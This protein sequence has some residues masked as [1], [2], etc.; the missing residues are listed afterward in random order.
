MEEVYRKILN[1]LQCAQ[2]KEAESV[3]L[4]ELGRLQQADA[5]LLFYLGT[6]ARMLKKN[7]AALVAFNAALELDADNTEYLQASASTCEALGDF[8][9]AFQLM[10]RVNELA[11]QDINV[12]AN[13]AVA[14]ARMNRNEEALAEY[15][16][17]LSLDPQH[18]TANVNYGTVLHKLKRKR[19]ALAHNRVA[20]SRL[21]H[22]FST[23]YNLA[24][25]LLANFEYQE[26][27]DYCLA[28]L[29]WQPK[30]AHLMMKKAIALAG[31][32][33]PEEA[34][35]AL[36]NARIIYPDVVKDL[37]PNV[38]GISDLYSV[39]MD[40][41]VLLY[42]A[43]YAEQ[44]SCW[45][46]YR[47]QYLITLR[48]AIH[49]KPYQNS[50]LLGSENA[51]KILSLDISADDRLKL[52]RNV[53]NKVAD[54][55]W[56]HTRGE[57][58]FKRGKR[59]KLRI[60]YISPDFRR[61]A[62]ASLTRQIYAL[63]DR[64]SFEIYAYSLH[65]AAETDRYRLHI[66]S[67]CDTFR[68]VS[69][70]G[71]AEMAELIY[72]DEIDILVD[73]AGYTAFSRTEVMAMRPAPVQMQYLG[74]GATTMGADFIDYVMIDKQLC[75]DGR[76][77]EYTEQPIRLP[78]AMYPYDNEIDHSPT[79]FSRA[80]FD[81]PEDAFVFC[82]LNSSYK[83][84]PVIFER[85]MNILKA[86]PNSVLWF[87]G[88]GLDVQD[89]LERE[90]EMRGV[91]ISRLV[92]TGR[93]PLEQHLPRYQLA[94]LFLDTYWANAHTT[95]A[96]ALWQGLPLITIMGEVSSARGAA[97]ILTALEMPELI[98]QDFD[99]YEQLAIFYA[100]HPAEYAA[101]REKLKAKR[102]TAP[103]Y[104]TK[105]TVKHIESA[106]KLAWERYQAGLPPAPID[107]PEILDPALRK[108]I[109]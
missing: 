38:R 9:T 105:L 87:L 40:G 80:D 86:I 72:S 49:N 84:E 94:D 85:W 58:S 2:Y 28:G 108:S 14:L 51:F 106:Y 104:N 8:E 44:V 70:L 25:T 7:D 68:D 100:T 79:S 101:M 41:R 77:D 24:D 23:L 74:F 89:N 76:A 6:S 88:K 83:I 102:Y 29:Q 57:F 10:C 55:A 97:S 61:H 17:V 99:E 92:F 3:C 93:V 4:F 60:A 32:N 15:A 11:P 27:L 64:S 54:Y 53:A 33:R 103:M 63:H 36:S 107:V 26:A 45:W 52:L 50:A 31:L 90:A 12:R 16:S 73:L 35:E 62:T 109:H 75:L 13:Y 91:D 78:H 21:P 59:E 65:N 67:T 66:E 5:Q 48:E 82:C 98:A 47:Q 69:E 56:L 42:E 39:Y 46:H 1:L 43:R 19:E 37:L 95:A 81:L 34:L 22:L 20:H 30:H 71:T 96:E 18:V